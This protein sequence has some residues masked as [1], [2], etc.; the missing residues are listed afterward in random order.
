LKGIVRKTMTKIA[1]LIGEEIILKA[2]KSNEEALNKAYNHHVSLD[3]PADILDLI[4]RNYEDE[5]R[6]LQWV[7]QALRTRLW[8]QPAAHP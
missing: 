3:F 7:E 5:K 6:H 4:K 2:M 1:G 8:E